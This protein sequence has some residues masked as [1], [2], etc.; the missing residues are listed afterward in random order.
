MQNGFYDN[1]IQSTL[2]ASYVLALKGEI[3]TNSDI[4]W[5]DNK[6]IFRLGASKKMVVVLCDEDGVEICNE[7]TRNSLRINISLSAP[8]KEMAEEIADAIIKV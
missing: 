2:A 5:K 3:I 8:M 1:A 7:D 6:I 4:T